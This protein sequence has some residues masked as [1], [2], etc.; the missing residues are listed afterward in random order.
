MSLNAQ[1][2]VSS[3]THDPQVYLRLST[4][5]TRSKAVKMVSNM[6]YKIGGFQ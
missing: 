4:V 3:S 1:M 2:Y 5:A 6:L